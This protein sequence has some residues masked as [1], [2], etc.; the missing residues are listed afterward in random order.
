MPRH[1]NCPHLAS[2]RRRFRWRFLLAAAC[3]PLCAGCGEDWQAETYPAHGRIAINGEPPAGA[4]VELRSVH[5]QPD[6]RDSR[7]WGVVDAEGRFV[8][9]TYEAG[10]GAPR[11]EYKVIIRWP[12]DV[13][14]PSLAD[15]LGGAYATSDKSQW[16]VSIEEGEN[17]LPSIDITGAK[18]ASKEKA[19]APRRA[20]PGPL[21]G[22]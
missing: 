2:G 1:R 6:V 18:V 20:P 15:R 17:E 5:A 7:P 14:Q 3:L 4:I 19:V 16:S 13:T 22:T 8:L 21:T 11:G 10:D 9:S 12:P